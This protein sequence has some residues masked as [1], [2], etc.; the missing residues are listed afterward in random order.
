MR[1]P[2]ALESAPSASKSSRRPL[3]LLRWLLAIVFLI[4]VVIVGD[5]LRYDLQSYSLLVHF[6]DPHAAVPLL[7]WETSVIST[8]EVEIPTSNGPIPGRL[9]LP[10][11]S[12]NA[13]GMVVAHGIH[14][15]GMDEPR[16][17]NF[18]RAVAGEG[19]AVLTP[20]IDSLADYRVDATSILTI[21]QSVL[22][23]ERRQGQGPVTIAGISF[24]GGLSLLAATDPQYAP[25]I[26]ALVLMGAYEDLSRVS[27][28]LVTSEAELPEGR[29]IPYA[30]HDYGA[31]VFVY[32]HLQQFF[33]TSDLPIAREALRSWLWEQPQDALPL[34]PK[35]SP[36]S[37][38]VMNALLARRIDLLRPQLLQVINQD[39][40]EL[41]AISPEGHLASLHIPVYVLHGS[42]DNIIPST[43]SLW[44][45]KDVPSVYLRR[46]LIT[47]AFSHVDP[48]SNMAWR[49]KLQ[50]VRF[51]AAVLRATR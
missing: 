34:I 8:Q 23:L 19:Y 22:W 2:A 48:A 12:E 42:A 25:H 28:F 6:A 49:D 29:F 35:L 13:P 33:P 36:A 4:G 30:A 5:D 46:V 43:E 10:A 15:L 18:A 1:E 11:G 45:E 20:Q 24:A 9:Y 14:R 31:A 50:L 47:P 17:V 41:A 27:R 3:Q 16:L 21:G 44:L 40:D 37:R 38:S 51:I 7:R 39:Q 26:R 32:A